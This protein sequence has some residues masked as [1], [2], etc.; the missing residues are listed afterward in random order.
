MV[1]N[2]R[3]LALFYLRFSLFLIMNI[4]YFNRFSLVSAFYWRMTAL[5]YCPGS[6]STSA[7]V[8]HSIHVCPSS[9]APLS[10]LSR[11]SRSAGLTSRCHVANSLS[12]NTEH[13]WASPNEVTE[14]GA[15]MQSEASQKEEDKPCLSTHT[16]AVQ[17]DGTDGP[18]FRAAVEMQSEHGLWTQSGKERVGWIKRRAWSHTHLHCETLSFKVKLYMCILHN[19]NVTV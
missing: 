4:Y 19:I 5:R 14:T 8:S 17:E 18:V 2:K 3:Q 12:Y 9:W 15:I 7:W 11:L 10:R 16:C 6:C 13:I 1:P